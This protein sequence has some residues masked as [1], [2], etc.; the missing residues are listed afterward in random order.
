M[1]GLIQRIKDIQRH[2]GAAVDGVF[3]PMT[4]EA[5]WRGMHG[6]IPADDAGGTPTLPLDERT[7]KNIATLDPKVRESFRQFACLAKASAATLGCDY[8]MVCGTRTFA[9]QAELY[10]L[11]RTAPGEKVTNARAGFSNHNFGIAGDFGVFRGKAYLDSTDPA[12][13]AKVHRL[14]SEHALACGLEWGGS[15]A[16]LKDLPHYEIATGLSMAE[17][18][19]KF[20][21]GGSIV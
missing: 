7:L 18:R 20:S 6:D 21:K 3:G 4:A 10:A 8:V 16:S 2:Y 15:W 14:C 1:S 19:E 13:A 5:V 12:T 11:G 9:E 17:K